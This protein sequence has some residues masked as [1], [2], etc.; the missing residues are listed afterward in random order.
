MAAMSNLFHLHHR[1]E[2]ALGGNGVRVGDRFGQG[3]RRNLPGQSP[4]VLAPAARALLAAVADDRVPVAIRFG[5][6][7]GCDLKRERFVVLVEFTSA[8]RRRLVCTEGDAEPHIHV[9]ARRCAREAKGR[10]AD[11]RPAL[12]PTTATHNTNHTAFISHGIFS[13]HVP[14]GS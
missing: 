9:A 14:V 1:I 8:R 3:D 6:V 4:F 13:T 10:A 7:S 12:A 2:R 11:L 5:L